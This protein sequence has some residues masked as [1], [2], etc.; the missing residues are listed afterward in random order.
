MT[1]QDQPEKPK[2]VM[3]TCVYENMPQVCR[4][5]ELSKYRDG[6]MYYRPET[7]W[8]DLFRDKYSALKGESDD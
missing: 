1:K 5:F 2:A 4:S 3:Q 7:G 8:C 6:C